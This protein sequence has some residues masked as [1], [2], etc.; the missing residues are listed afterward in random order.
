MRCNLVLV[1]FFGLLTAC[2]RLP[3]L[4]PA[5]EEKNKLAS[6]AQDDCGF[7]QNSFG[8]RVSWK[9]SLPIKI[10]LSLDFSAESEASLREAAKR[11]EDIVARTLFVFERGNQP[12]GTTRDY[13]NSISFEN[14]WGDMDR[15][16]QAVTALSWYNSQMTEADLRINS[17][18][19][20]FYT[21]KPQTSDGVH[22]T[23]LFVHELGHILGLKHLQGGSVMT[24]VL[25]YLLKRDLPTTQDRADIKCEYN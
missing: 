1:L 19:F 22:L 15:R 5:D 16:L 24:E 20:N 8:Q 11:W 10:Y 14:V 23:S 25:D 13:R 6:A 7:V 2:D 4:G 12:V 9:Q 18:H 21:D 3:R 17:Q